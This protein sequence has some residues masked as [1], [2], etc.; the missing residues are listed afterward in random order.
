MKENEKGQKGE[1]RVASMMK[2]YTAELTQPLS[3]P[4]RNLHQAYSLDQ[5]CKDPSFIQ[6]KS[7]SLS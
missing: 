3:M 5:V 7:T 2:E 6:P 4:Q 1:R